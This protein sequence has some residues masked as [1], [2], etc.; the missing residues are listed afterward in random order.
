MKRI[1]AID[2][3]SRKIGVALS[4]PLRLTA[5][6]VSVYRRKK[7]EED[8]GYLLGL[9]R[10]NDADEIVVGRPVYLTG[11]ESAVSEAIEPLFAAL[12][13]RFDGTV[14]WCEE[15]L[16]SKEAERILVEKGYPPLE[17]RK[18]RDSFAAALILT[19]YLQEKH[20]GC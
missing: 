20:C 4:D 5:S 16:S 3:G 7:L 17:I 8:T 13:E 15:R 14:N 6:P 11:E 12:R 1:M 9:A 2:V 18:R 10:E 19:W